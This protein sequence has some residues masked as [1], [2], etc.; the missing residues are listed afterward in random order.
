MRLPDWGRGR[1]LPGGPAR[2]AEC[3][4]LGGG[5]DGS[6]ET[7]R[8]APTAGASVAGGSY[9]WLKKKLEKSRVP[10]NGER[11]GSAGVGTEEA[12]RAKS[13]PEVRLGGALVTLVCAVRFPGR[14]PL[15]WRQSFSVTS[16]GSRSQ[17][18][19]TGKVTVINWYH[20]GTGQ[21][22]RGTI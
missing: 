2:D 16:Q 4:G 10:T 18:P 5:A 3:F 21:H 12:R 14:F 7:P 9:A 8:M 19:I 17:H 11:T 20:P 6:P 15:P 13:R 1:R 22:Q